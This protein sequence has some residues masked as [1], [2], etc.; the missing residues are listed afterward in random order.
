METWWLHQ[1]L[2]GPFEQ[3][4]ERVQNRLIEYEIE[5]ILELFP[6]SDKISPVVDFQDFVDE[7]KFGAMKQLALELNIF[8]VEDPEKLIVINFNHA[9]GERFT[10][11]S[12]HQII[13][14][15]TDLFECQ[16]RRFKVRS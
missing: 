8:F 13:L 5:L 9:H 7:W 4:K 3:V 12:L 2:N 11:F 14:L 6:N 1:R 15:R 10:D 16:I